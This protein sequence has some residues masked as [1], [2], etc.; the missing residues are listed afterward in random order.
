MKK[1]I[2]KKELRTEHEQKQVFHEIK[3][4][5]IEAFEMDDVNDTTPILEQLVQIVKKVN[6]D[7]SEANEKLMQWSE[8]K[9]ETKVL[10]KV[11]IEIV[12][13]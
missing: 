9:F 3:G 11:S 6:S 7:V 13:K 10:E 8:R 4:I 5:F 1:K 2:K 12:V